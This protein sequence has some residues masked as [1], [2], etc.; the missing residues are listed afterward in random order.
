MSLKYLAAYCLAQLG[1]KANPT[2]DD[3]KRILTEVGVNVNEGDLEH[4]VKTLSGKQLHEVIAAGQ[5]KLAN[6]SFGGGAGAAPAKAEEK[7][8]EGKEAAKAPAKKVEEPKVEEAEVGLGG[9][10]F[11][12]DF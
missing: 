10:L 6:V 7:K 1:G 5:K 11:G 12:D 2:K 9:G 8:P 4:T 3:V